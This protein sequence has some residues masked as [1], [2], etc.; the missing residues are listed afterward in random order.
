VARGRFAFRLASALTGALA[1]QMI[2]VLRLTASGDQ[3]TAL[4]AAG[5]GQHTTIAAAWSANG[6]TSWTLS[7]PLTTSGQAITAASFGPGQTAA[8]I[9]AGGHGAMLADGRWQL[10]LESPRPDGYSARSANAVRVLAA[11]VAGPSAPMIAM[12]RPA[13]ASRMTSAVP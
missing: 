7:P 4:L 1:T 12:T 3:I 10:R 13:S 9:T 8:I 2:T 5:T 6:G 11:Q